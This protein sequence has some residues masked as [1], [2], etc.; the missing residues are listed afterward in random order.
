MDTGHQNRGGWITFPFIIA[1]TAALS[2]AAGGWMYNLMVYLIQEFHIKSIDAALIFNLVNGCTSLIPVVAAIVAD[3][4]LGCY[5]VVWI[6]SVISVLGI[7]FLYLI[8]SLH[9]LRPQPC[10]ELESLCKS[11]TNL[12]FTAL[13]T[14]IILASIGTGGVR[15]TITTMGADQFVKPKDQQV[16]FDWYF[17]AT[18]LVSVIAATA[19][20]Y[21][22]DNLSWATGFGLSVAANLFG[23]LIFL[24]G[25]RFYYRPKLDKSP[26]TDIAHVIVATIRKWNV[27][28]SSK[29]EEY[30]CGHDAKMK[31]MKAE[32]TKSFRFLNRAALITNGNVDLEGSNADPWTTCTVSQVEELKTLIKI[33]PIWLSNIL[34]GTAIGV[35]SSLSILQSLT[36][37]RGITHHFKIPAASVLVFVLISTA[38]SLTIFD[39]FLMPACKKLFSLTLSPLQRIGTGHILIVISMAISAV[40]ETKRRN[41]AE[42]GN[43]LERSMVVPMSVFW[44]VP[45]LAITGIGNAFQFP[46]QINLFYQEFPASLKS[47]STALNH[48]VIAISFFMS[49]ALMDLVR[50]VTNWLPDNIN[51]GRLQNVYWMLVL[52]G[53]INFCYYLVCA[54]LYKYHNVDK[55]EE[56]SC[57]E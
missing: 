47:M 54:C 35:Q 34:L 4:F 25:T 21:I 10:Q 3:S 39:R 32:P 37:D 7:K 57:H 23:L 48:L 52:I 26:F 1:S 49:S 56:K 14:G 33:F 22:E 5:A 53:L 16:Y 27:P 12:Q 40:V 36:M 9:C 29:S 38:I 6:F 43:L 17:V 42:S 13:Y 55:V 2:L 15:S 20:V 50:K 51:N 44:L 24:L 18:S 19:M 11:P 28:S 41:A 30:Y 8:S 46:G 45:Q 31:K